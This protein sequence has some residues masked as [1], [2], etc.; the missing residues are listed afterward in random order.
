MTIISAPLIADIGGTNA[1]FARVD[2]VGR[3][4][5]V[6]VA[7]CADTPD[8]VEAVNRYLEQDHEGPP[9]RACFA[10][11][12]PVDGD[13]I[14]LTNGPW[15]FSREEIRRELQLDD[16]LVVNDF[17][18]QAASLSC[19]VDIDLESIG[20]GRSAVGGNRVILGPGTGLGIAAAIPCGDHWAIVSG[21]GGH[22]SFAPV[23]A[24][25]RQVTAL[26]AERHG[27]V[28]N[29]RL[30]SG[31]GLV[32]IHAALS[33]IEGQSIP[34]MSAERITEDA[35]AGRSTVASR[36]VDMFLDM[37][38]SVAG[39]IALYFGA[40]GGVYIA[41]GIVPR[42]ASR[43]DPERFRRRFSDKGRMAGYV[44]TIATH[45]VTTPHS[46]LIGAAALLNSRT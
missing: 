26:L 7:R 5:D 42:I 2:A 40:T 34:A 22:G 38:A 39:D 9:A 41:G 20:D 21:E 28:S 12:A 29:E 13:A 46:G 19:L 15:A 30:L 6:M 37:L 45:R 14:A 10:V 16:L 11:A 31:T 18:A 27:R 44:A 36:T 24:V 33:R 8:V 35:L 4:R 25:E 3:P 43:I 32:E 17:A 23:N 1:R